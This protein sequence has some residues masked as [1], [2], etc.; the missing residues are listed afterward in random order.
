[1][2]RSAPCHPDRAHFAKELCRPCYLYNGTK[3]A[4]C[5]PNRAHRALGLCTACYYQQRQK[6]SKRVT[7]MRAMI[8][9]A[10]LVGLNRC[11]GVPCYFL[12]TCNNLGTIQNV[13]VRIRK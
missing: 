1:M 12:Y 13:F 4:S 2:G 3:R 7:R 8:K 5:H 9:Q 11:P 10:S 6:K